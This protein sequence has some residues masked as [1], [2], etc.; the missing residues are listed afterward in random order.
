MTLRYNWCILAHLNFEELQA[1]LQLPAR[2]PRDHATTKV[3][4][5]WAVPTPILLVTTL[6]NV[7]AECLFPPCSL[8]AT[9]LP[10]YHAICAISKPALSSMG[11]LMQP[12]LMAGGEATITSNP[13]ENP[14]ENVNK[15]AIRLG[16]Y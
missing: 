1:N 3:Y 10:R 2:G 14:I 9:P 5:Y 15:I 6:N 11:Q 12:N 16:K 8:M 13:L 4:E 7:L